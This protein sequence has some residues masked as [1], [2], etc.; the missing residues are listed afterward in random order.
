MLSSHLCLGLP[1]GLLPSGLPTTP[2]LPHVRHMPRPSHETHVKKWVIW[3]K[4]EYWCERGNRCMNWA[5]R[6]EDRLCFVSRMSRHV[7]VLD[8]IRTSCTN[9]NNCLPLELAAVGST[10]GEMGG[11]AVVCRFLLR[12]ICFSCSSSCKNFSLASLNR[13]RGDSGPA[14]AFLPAWWLEVDDGEGDLCR[15]SAARRLLNACKS[16]GVPTVTNMN[17][18]IEGTLTCFRIIIN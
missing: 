9:D 14:D 16:G 8:S 11:S 4:A 1:S 15:S 5:I 18:T 7:F 17:Q 12:C 2:H 3:R 10:A 13:S 6:S